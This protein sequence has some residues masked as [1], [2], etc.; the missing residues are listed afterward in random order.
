[1]LGEGDRPPE[2]NED[3][4]EGQHG[5][6]DG[7]QRQIYEVKDAVVVAASSIFRK[8]IKVESK[9][10]KVYQQNHK[11]QHLCHIHLLAT[12]RLIRAPAVVEHYQCE[13]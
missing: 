12:A 11:Q 2:G 1:L 4:E 7:M 8:P 9:R 10:H 13:D 6:P 5:F 3:D